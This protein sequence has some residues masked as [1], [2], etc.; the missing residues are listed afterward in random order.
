M[1]LS[2]IAGIAG[3]AVDPTKATFLIGVVDCNGD[4]VSGAVITTN[5]KGT[6]LYIANGMPSTSAVATDAVTGS[7]IVANVD[8]SN[9]L[10]G[11]TVGDK[12]LRSHSFDSVP[13]VMSQTEIRP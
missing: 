1:N 4:P 13:G 6:T 7:A 12:T 5:P 11:A 10:F 3:V 2:T 8:V 9:T